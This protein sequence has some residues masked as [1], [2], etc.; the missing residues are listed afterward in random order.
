MPAI[1]S[2]PATLAACF[3]VALGGAVGSVLRYLTGLAFAT[4]ASPDRIPGKV[5]AFPWATFAV[6]IAGC[7]AMGLL[8][9]WLARPDGLASHAGLTENLRLLLGVGLLGGFTTFSAFGLELVWMAERGAYL[10]AAVYASSS[11]LLGAVAVMFGL[12]LIRVTG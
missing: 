8:A 7:F 9:G 6:N 11:L 5:M 4:P 3:Y 2:L 1:A 10:Q 12:A